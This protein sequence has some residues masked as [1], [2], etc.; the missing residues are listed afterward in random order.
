M[1]ILFLDELLFDTFW[2]VVGFI[3]LR[4]LEIWVF[5]CEVLV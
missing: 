4:K 2:F 1:E 5:V 3:F